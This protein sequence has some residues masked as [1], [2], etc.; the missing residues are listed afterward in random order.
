MVPKA[1][2]R[3]GRSVQEL[4]SKAQ[5]DTADR[6]TI[7]KLRETLIKKS[8]EYCKTFPKCNGESKQGQAWCAAICYHVLDYN[9]ETILAEDVKFTIYGAIEI[10]LRTR[11]LHMEPGTIGFNSFSP[12][13]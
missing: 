9:V 7:S 4:E 10:G 8:R 12:A 11:V 3:T 5:K 6:T 1:L 2:C 13:V